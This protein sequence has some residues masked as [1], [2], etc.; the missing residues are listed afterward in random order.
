MKLATDFRDI[1]IDSLD[2]M[3]AKAINRGIPWFLLNL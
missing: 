3:V 1:D 2:I